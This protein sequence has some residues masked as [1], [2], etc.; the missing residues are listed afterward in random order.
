MTNS[1]HGTRTTPS[2]TLTECAIEKDDAED[3]GRHACTPGSTKGHAQKTFDSTQT[4]FKIIKNDAAV[5]YAIAYYLL[6][7]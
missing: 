3:V 6:L 1:S 5:Y 7:Q 2:Q 4:G